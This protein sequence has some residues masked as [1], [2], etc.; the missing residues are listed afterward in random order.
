MFST[1][2]VSATQWVPLSASYPYD[3][4]LKVKSESIDFVDGYGGIFHPLYANSRDLSFNKHTQ[5]ALTSAQSLF[6]IIEET[7]IG[8][9]SLGIYTTIWKDNSIVTSDNDQL[10][11]AGEAPSDDSFFRLLLNDN[12]TVSFLQGNA[13]YMT[14]DAASPYYMRMESELP[15][16]EI[17][18]QQFDMQLS[19]NN[20]M[21][22]VATIPNPLPLLGP[23]TV[24]RFVSF[25]TGT[26][27]IQV[28]GN[29]VFDPSSI[30]FILSGDDFTY[31]VDGITRDQTWVKYYNSLYNTKDSKT[32]EIQ[33][34]VSGVEVSRLVNSAYLNDLDYSEEFGTMNINIANSKNTM[35]AEYE[36]AF[37]EEEI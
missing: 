24:E 36:Y 32:V 12:N 4:Y 23:A 35:T 10:F 31:N 1:G 18:R 13:R 14:V 2:P 30:L 15:P 27:A 3:D 7:K 34:S 25:N 33:S 28:N 11:L 29:A 6:D 5:F 9:A 16:G 26:S 21:V 22:L 37:S 8:T 17:F 20:E 19:V